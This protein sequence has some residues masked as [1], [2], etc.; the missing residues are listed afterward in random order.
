MLNQ[1]SRN[2][3]DTRTP[4]CDDYSEWFVAGSIQYVK[5][6]QYYLISFNTASFS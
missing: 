3:D 5:T 4:L 1:V 6:V 2:E